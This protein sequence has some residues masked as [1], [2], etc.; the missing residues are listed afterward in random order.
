[1]DRVPE[2][3]DVGADTK[4]L[5]FGALD[6]SAF[7]FSPVK[8][9]NSSPPPPRR[10][11]RKCTPTTKVEAKDEN[12]DVGFA[13]KPSSR[14]SPLKR[15]RSPKMEAGEP[16]RGPSPASSKK[17]KRTYAPPETYAHL[18]GLQDYLTYDLDTLQSCSV[19]SSIHFMPYTNS[20]SEHHNDSP[21]YMSADTGHHFANPTNHYYRC[22]H[23][24]GLTPK[25]LPPSEDHTLPD[26]SL[27]LTNLVT[28]PSA[29]AAELSPAEMTK[30]V[31][32]LLAKIAEYRP[33][34]VCF[35]GVGIWKKF[36][37]VIKKTAVQATDD[38]V[39]GPDPV[40][41]KRKKAN[42]AGG[43]GL[44]PYILHHPVK[45]VESS[46]IPVRETLFFAMPS[47]SGR[48]VSHQLPDKV[49]LFAQLKDIVENVKRGGN[50][51]KMMARIVL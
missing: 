16:L 27:G 44:Q 25:L 49:K 41:G 10:S 1:M 3:D 22:L 42:S 15:R 11:S 48:V 31:P 5:T 9:G 24:S 14:G 30:G 23:R 39:P 7:T 13:I 34:V 46:G 20:S 12:D 43:I 40:D 50:D 19:A 47:T 32:T 4:P 26:Y 51:T 45:T 33:R 28:R 18:K 21:G 8:S 38:G 36:E 35:V 37:S 17:A 2:F 29:E 6:P